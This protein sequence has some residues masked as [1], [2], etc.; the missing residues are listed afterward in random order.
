MKPA[1]PVVRRLSVLVILPL[2]I[3]LGASTVAGAVNSNVAKPANAKQQVARPAPKVA[4]P[5]DPQTA[6]ASTSIR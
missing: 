1:A 6:T 4:A 3:A 5:K 2:L